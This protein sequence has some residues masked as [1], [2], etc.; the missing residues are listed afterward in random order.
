MLWYGFYFEYTKKKKK[1]AA[2]VV[3]YNLNANGFNHCIISSRTCQLQ[4]I[5][6]RQNN[7]TSTKNSTVCIYKHNL[8]NS[9]SYFTGV[10]SIAKW[11]KYS[12]LGSFPDKTCHLLKN[13][14]YLCQFTTEFIAHAFQ[15]HLIF[16]ISNKHY[17]VH[18]LPCTYISTPGELRWG[19]WKK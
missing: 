18:H 9:K 19:S 12:P 6:F 10:T 5:R 16:S 15:I 3:N 13:Y 17:H 4:W 1:S 7:F 2:L 14:I 8:I 11:H